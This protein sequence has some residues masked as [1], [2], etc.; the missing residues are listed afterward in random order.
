MF[1]F[2]FTLQ[3]IICI[4][5]TTILRFCIY[6]PLICYLI[7]NKTQLWMIESLALAITDNLGKI[8]DSQ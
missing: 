8:Q 7:N 4:L 1:Y 2:K 3:N 5:H 6:M